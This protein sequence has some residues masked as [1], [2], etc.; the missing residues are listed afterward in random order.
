MIP[1]LIHNIWLEGYNNLP[2]EYKLNYINIKKI[3]PD[4]EFMIWDDEM[5]SKLLK[6]F[7]KINTIYKKIKNTDY[8]IKSY[9]ARYIILKEYGGLYYDIEYNCNSSFDNLFLNQDDNEGDNEGDNDND[10]NTYEN[11]NI[12]FISGGKT[13]LLDIFIPY[14]K[15]RYSISFVAMNKNHPI[16]DSVIEKIVFA[17]T[18]E[19]IKLALNASLEESNKYRINILNKVNDNYQCINKDTICY[20]PEK[21]S[22]D[23]LRKIINYIECYYKQI[24][25]FTLSIIIIVFVEYLYLH[26]VVHYGVTNFIPGMPGNTQQ[27]LQILNKSHKKKNSNKK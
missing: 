5:I 13:N 16:W 21:N 12:I 20:L 15:T 9:I 26:N 18:N 19:Q 17:T 14:K 24:F 27:P 10:D 4:W 6:R 11:N 1:K 8:E 7:P 25:L 3:N 23:F 2:N 22:W